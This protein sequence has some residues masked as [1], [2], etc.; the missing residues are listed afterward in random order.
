MT[1]SPLERYQQELRTPG[2]QEDSS[3]KQ[4]VEALDLLWRRLCEQESFGESS[5][6]ARIRAWARHESPPAIKGLYLWGGVG[7]GKTWL[8]DMFFESLPFERKMRTHFHRFMR[9]IHQE[10]KVLQSTK[11]PLDSVAENIAGQV[12]IICFDEFF[13]SDITDAM[14]L[15]RLLE[16]LFD[17]GVVLVATS[18]V[19]PEQLYK[20]GLQRSR[21]M[22]AIELLK[23]KTEV[24]HL[25]GGVDYRLRALEQ[26]ELYYAPLSE[27]SHKALGEC[28]ERL[29]PEVNAI[30]ANVPL[31]VE[32][33]TLQAYREAEDVV[34]FDFKELCDGPRSQNDYIELAREYHAVLLENVPVFNGRNDDQTRRFINMVDEFYDRGVKL[35]LSAETDVQ[36]LYQSG[37]LGFEFERTVSRILEMQSTVYLARAHKA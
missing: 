14:I 10:L 6:L 31:E 28:F 33:R 11:N 19:E 35:I 22:P 17:R 24:L 7:R 25:D 27:A 26:A 16:G 20:D 1:F 2:V 13:V 36:S 34:W 21:F 8:M 3:Q 4:A 12:R 23:T 32:G 29:V 18:N 9:G 5:L 15:A 30:R 37:K